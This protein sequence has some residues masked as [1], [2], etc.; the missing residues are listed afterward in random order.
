MKKQHSS[1]L[2]EPAILALKEEMTRR[3]EVGAIPSVSAPHESE[4][5]GSKEKGGN[6][7]RSLLRVHLL[8]LERTLDGNITSQH[9][10][11]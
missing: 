4:S 1:R 5:S 8:D 9:L 7:F 3:V 11:I 10:V 6:L 2:S